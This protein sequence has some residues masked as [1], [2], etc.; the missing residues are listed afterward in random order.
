MPIRRINYF[1]ALT[2]LL[3]GML[4]GAQIA[5]AQSEKAATNPQPNA[6]ANAAC[7]TCHRTA[8]SYVVSEW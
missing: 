4:P 6:E 2:I 5:Q 8:T 7:L 3:I 1:A